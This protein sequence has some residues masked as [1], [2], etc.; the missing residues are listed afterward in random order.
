VKEELESLE[1]IKSQ[2]TEEIRSA[3]LR[4]IRGIQDKVGAANAI[5]SSLANEGTNLNLEKEEDVLFASML[6]IV[7]ADIGRQMSQYRRK[8]NAKK[9]E[10]LCIERGINFR[11]VNAISVY[12]EQ[13][14]KVLA[15]WI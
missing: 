3:I 14:L 15:S 12:W 7:T 1:T 5:R 4:L 6:S 13:L 8:E 11:S 10:A 2:S 9:I